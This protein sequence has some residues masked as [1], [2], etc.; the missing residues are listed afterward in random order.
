MRGTVK[1]EININL[2]NYSP[3]KN[4]IQYLAFKI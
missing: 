1:G 3:N 2:N 4:Y